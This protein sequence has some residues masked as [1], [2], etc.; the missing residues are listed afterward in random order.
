MWNVRG[1]WTKLLKTE[2]LILFESVQRFGD[3]WGLVSGELTRA[4]RT[5]KTIPTNSDSKS[6]FM[7][8]EI[9]TDNVWINFLI[10]VRC[11][12]YNLKK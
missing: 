2:N 1:T 8:A 3:N 5:W 12:K 10:L 4:A 7:E 11:V 9:I 6:L